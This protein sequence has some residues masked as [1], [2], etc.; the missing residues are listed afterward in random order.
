MIVRMGKGQWIG[1]FEVIGGFH[2]SI[3]RYLGQELIA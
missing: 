1:G 3:A 2:Y